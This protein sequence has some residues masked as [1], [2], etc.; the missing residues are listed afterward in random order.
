MSL[1][2]PLAFSTFC[3]AQT[4]AAVEW[5][6]PAGDVQGTR[7]STLDLIDKTNVGSLVEE[8]SYPTYVKN[9]HQGSPLVVN[10]VMYYVT[11]FPNQLIAVDLATNTK[12]WVF[13]PNPG[14]FATGLT[15][16]DVVNRG[17]A[18]GEAVIK[19]V[20]TPLIVYTLLDGNVVAVNASTGAQVWRTKVADPWTGETLNTPVLIVK[21]TVI[22]GSSGSEM[23]V[24]GS[25]RALDLATGVKKWRA[26]ATGP[27]ADVLI[28]SNTKPYY[29]KDQGT[30]LGSESWP[31]TLWQQGGGTTWAWI[32]ADPANNLV[33]Y[34][35][36]QP[37]TFNPTMRDFSPP[38]LLPAENK[39]GASIFAR[40]IDTGSAKW[41][42]QLT[43]WDNWDYDAVNEDTVVDL[44]LNPSDAQPTPVIVHFNKNGF[45]YVLNRLKGQLL[46][47]NQFGFQNWATGIDLTTG[48]P[49]VDKSKL[50]VEGKVT[51][52]ICPSAFG[53]KDWEGSAWSPKTS[54]FYF[55]A[56]NMCMNYEPLKVNYIAGTPFVGVDI[57]IGLHLDAKGNPEYNMGEF[58]AFDPVAG[59]RKWALKENTPVFGGALATAGDVVFYGT[60]D[61][62]FKAVDAS[63]GAVLLSMK[64]EC[65]VV[66]APITFT[67]ADG[68]QRVAITTGL[69]YLNGGFSGSGKC[70]T[71]SSSVATA[72]P[73]NNYSRTFTAP[74]PAGLTAPP[75]GGWVHVF[76]LP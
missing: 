47:A 44:K 65:G 53:V 23:G 57:G 61:K 26:Y 31:G 14:R 22:F 25:V 58:V 64:L 69:G 37:G 73:A 4:S 62:Y 42:Y 52:Y 72:I 20:N 68:K 21:N 34:G 5:R 75:A 71:T 19:G 48:Y 3:A 2:A 36:S 7:Y 39:W 56:F 45:V 51:N 40:D 35:T 54:L 30:N 29:A 66:S 1:A 55:G 9:S 74:T 60:L 18:Y 11:P 15:C 43:P 76:K 17:A 28:D 10:G 63:T 12:K 32:T 13:S 8:F 50:T 59:Q 6:T 67:G 24:R 49:L 70:A 38:K 16:C 33:F 27:D 46:S 41:V